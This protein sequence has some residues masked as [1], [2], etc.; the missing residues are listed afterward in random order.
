[1]ITR[2]SHSNNPNIVYRTELLQDI[3]CL[4]SKNGVTASYI[5]KYKD[6]LSQ[7]NYSTSIISKS[8]KKAFKKLLDRAM[9]AKHYDSYSEATKPGKLFYDPLIF[10]ASS[11]PYMYTLLNHTHS[12]NVLNGWIKEQINLFPSNCSQLQIVSKRWG[13]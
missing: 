10:T 8:I 13:I 7:F 1:M 4:V 5:N 9:A 11:M 6:R 3:F 2:C 12:T